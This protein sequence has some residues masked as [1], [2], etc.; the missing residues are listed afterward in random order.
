MVTIDHAIRCVRAQ[1]RQDPDLDSAMAALRALTDAIYEA[2]MRGMDQEEQ[3]LLFDLY[4]QAAVYIAHAE[5]LTDVIVRQTGNGL[6][7]ETTAVYSAEYDD[8]DLFDD[9][10]SEPVLTPLPRR[11][12]RGRQDLFVIPG[13]R[14]DHNP[15]TP[16]PTNHLYVIHG[17]K[18][19]DPSADLPF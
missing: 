16:G 1:M 12:P 8:D 14:S 9:D 18:Q 17:G 7:A 2:R 6:E 15:V 4:G 13:G 19:D 11:V 5:H 3:A 10:Q